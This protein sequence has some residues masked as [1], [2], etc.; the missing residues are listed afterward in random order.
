MAV[1]LRHI[2]L[3]A[4]DANMLASF[5]CDVFGYVERRAPRRLS[6]EAVWR[7][8]GLPNSNILSIW[9]ALPDDTG[10]FLEIM[11]Y[12]PPGTYHRPAVND[13]GLAHLAFEVPDLAASLDSL[14]AAGGSMQG[15]VTNFGTDDAPLLIAYVRDPEGNILEL[16]QLAHAPARKE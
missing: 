7:G 4:R 6:G 12:D 2:S 5:Y 16:E 9:L 14:L 1:K 15:Q 8:N 10:P 11:E 13:P 3:T